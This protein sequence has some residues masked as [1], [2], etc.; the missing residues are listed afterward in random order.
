MNKIINKFV[1]FVQKA[2]V[3]FFLFLLYVFG[4]GATALLLAISGRRLPGSAAEDGGT[5]W[6]DAEGYG[7]DMSDCERES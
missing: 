1:A 3:T 6:K 4:F 5:F 2:A 7:S